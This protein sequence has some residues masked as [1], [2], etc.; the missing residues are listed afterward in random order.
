MSSKLYHLGIRGHVSRSTLADANEHR[1]WR[2]YADLARVLIGIAHPLYA[3]EPFGMDLDETVYALDATTV[4][5]SISLCPWAPY[6]R[7][8]GVVKIH[9]LLDLRG[10]IPTFI[11]ITHGRCNDL[12]VLDQLVFE[13]AAFYVMDRAYAGF[14]RNG[15]DESSGPTEAMRSTLA[16]S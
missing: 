1:N 11:D 7:S 2:V 3:N 8:R 16:G 10:N 5:V 12:R 9:T 6:A 13:P 4:D 14:A 15:Q